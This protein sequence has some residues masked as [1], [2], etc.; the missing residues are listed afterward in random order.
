MALDSDRECAPGLTYVVAP[1]T[2]GVD[3][4]AYPCAAVLAADVGDVSLPP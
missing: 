4:R 3:P 1:T 2:P